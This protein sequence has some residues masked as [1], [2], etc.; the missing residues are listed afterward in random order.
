MK[1]Y[2]TNMIKL[3]VHNAFEGILVLDQKGL[4]RHANS[5]VAKMFNYST[6]QLIGK[7]IELLIEKFKEDNF[8][9]ENLDNHSKNIFGIRNQYK[10]RR[11]DGSNFAF[12]LN[13]TDLIL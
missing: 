11:R 5:S 4:I 1:P 8:V 6:D 3:L 10:G 12:D 9:Y 2:S 13:V 7:P